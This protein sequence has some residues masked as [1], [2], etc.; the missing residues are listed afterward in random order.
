MRHRN[1][2]RKLGRT[3][4]HRK[5]TLR[6][7]ASHLFIHKRISTTLAKAKELR[8]F[9]EPLITKA[10]KGDLHSQRMV[11]DTLK[12]KEATKELFNN[13][14]PTIG[15]RPGGYTRV[16]KLGTRLGDAAS[17][18]MIEL[19]DYNE[20]ANEQAQFKESV[21]KASKEEVK[22]TEETEEA[23]VVEETETETEKDDK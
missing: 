1:K 13:I 17:L 19:V 18:G 2:H 3:A 10:R 12:N 6:S 9:V 11:M 14:V 4:S 16:I 8:L 15:D 21:K 5:A 7:L 22:E 23:T 20:Y